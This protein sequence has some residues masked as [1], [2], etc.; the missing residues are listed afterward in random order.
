MN[1]AVSKLLADLLKLLI[2]LLELLGQLL[3]GLGRLVHGIEIH[4]NFVMSHLVFSLSPK[5]AGPAAFNSAENALQLVHRRL[6]FLV[7]LRNAVLRLLEL[8][9]ETGHRADEVPHVGQHVARH[10]LLELVGVIPRPLVLQAIGGLVSLVLN[11]LHG[12]DLLREL[13]QGLGHDC[14]SQKK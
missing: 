4:L 13:R 8:L 10:H 9:A 5:G 11:L 2:D 12:L 14:V 6:G 7:G 1:A 3:I